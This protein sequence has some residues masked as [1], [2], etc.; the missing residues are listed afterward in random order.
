M[1]PS[2]QKVETGRSLRQRAAWPTKMSS[3]AARA[4]WRNPVSRK[5]RRKEREKK[6][7]GRKEEGREGGTE[8]ENKLNI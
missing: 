4:T 8:K 5:K 1:N 2:A 3:R 6:K 7:K